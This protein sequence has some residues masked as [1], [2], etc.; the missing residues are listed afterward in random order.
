MSKRNNLSQNFLKNG[1]VIKKIENMHKYIKIEDEIYKIIKKY[2][3]L[4]ININKNLLFN[5]LHKYLNVNK[6]NQLRL[7]I[8]R[9]LNSKKWFK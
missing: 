8:Y 4:K 9:E 2:L 5:D 7:K 3:K 1:Y 6:L